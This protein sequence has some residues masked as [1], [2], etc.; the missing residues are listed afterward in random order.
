MIHRQACAPSLAPDSHAPREQPSHLV[1]DQGNPLEGSHGTLAE[2][3]SDHIFVHT[4]LVMVLYQEAALPNYTS[5]VAEIL[6]SFL[7]PAQPSGDDSWAADAR[8]FVL[9]GSASVSGPGFSMP[10][11]FSRCFAGD[12]MRFLRNSFQDHAQ[13][14]MVVSCSPRSAFAYKRKKNA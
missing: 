4:F 1:A 5:A 2:V 10:R 3:P 6:G 13:S 14:S 12:I 8:K 11:R 7:G 9:H